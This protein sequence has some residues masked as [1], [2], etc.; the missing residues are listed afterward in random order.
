MQCYRGKYQVEVTNLVSACSVS[1]HPSQIK[2]GRALHLSQAMLN[3]NVNTSLAFKPVSGS[4]AF[5]CVSK[6]DTSCK[7]AVIKISSGPLNQELKVIMIH[8]KIFI[9]S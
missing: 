9:V 1:D 4:L 3:T 2:S 5:I 7:P 8:L 6:S